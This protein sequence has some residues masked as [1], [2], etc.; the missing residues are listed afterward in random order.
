MSDG[1]R[2]LLLAPAAIER[3]DV[4]AADTAAL[5]LDVDI[6]VAKRLGLELVLVE[7]EPGVGPVDL[8][9]SE[10]VGVRHGEN[11]DEIGGEMET[12]TEKG[13]A[14]ASM[15]QVNTLEAGERPAF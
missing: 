7:F 5:D 9:A 2:V 1:Q 15:Q 3:V 14:R 12:V 4:A 8:E 6:I 13:V 11:G 10:L